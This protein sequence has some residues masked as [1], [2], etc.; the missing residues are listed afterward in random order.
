M[1]KFPQPLSPEEI[2]ARIAELDREIIALTT[3]SHL[4]E[5]PMKNELGS[6]LEESGLEEESNF[7]DFSKEEARVKHLREEKAELQ[8]RLE[9]LAKAA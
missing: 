7:N 3:T 9:S 5:V 1:E 2:Q 4:S 8:S 6:S